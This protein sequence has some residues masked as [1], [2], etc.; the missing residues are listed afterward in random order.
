MY[1]G[2]NS[3]PYPGLNVTEMFAKCLP[4]RIYV[5]IFVANIREKL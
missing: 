5:A 2:S 4:S 1:A 3:C